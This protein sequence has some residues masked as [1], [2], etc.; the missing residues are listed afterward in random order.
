MRRCGA[1]CRSLM[2][3]CQKPAVAKYAWRCATHR[4]ITDEDR[5]LAKKRRMDAFAE[6]ERRVDDAQRKRE[7]YKAL[8][9]LERLVRED[10]RRWAEIET[11]LDLL[12]MIRQPK[13]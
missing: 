1:Q 3:Y 2:G 12:D 13:T 11:V 6:S 7:E 10:D 8:L 9:T 5:A 4:P